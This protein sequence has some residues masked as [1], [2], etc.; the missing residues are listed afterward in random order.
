MHEDTPYSATKTSIADIDENDVIRRIN[1]LDV[2]DGWKAKFRIIAEAGGPK[3]PY[4]KD[5]PLS[6]RLEV[7]SNILAALFGPFY[8]IAKGMWKKGLV[9]G[10]GSQLAFFFIF[11]I[12]DHYGLIRPAYFSYPHLSLAAAAGAFATFANVD[13]YKKMVLDENGWL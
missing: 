13:Y 12:L 7:R 4:L 1:E 10:F 2:S 8:Y 9:I 11:L 3:L 6:K 5:L